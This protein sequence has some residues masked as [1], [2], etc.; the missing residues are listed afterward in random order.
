MSTL[1]R[2]ATSGSERRRRMAAII[3]APVLTGISLAAIQAL[4]GVAMHQIG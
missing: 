3:A 4:V 1:E 2:E